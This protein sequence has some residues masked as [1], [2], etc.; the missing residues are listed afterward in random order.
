MKF[1]TEYDLR[2]QFNE[3]PFTDYKMEEN[4]RLTPGARQFLSD[5]RI[6]LFESGTKTPFGASG[7]TLK[8]QGTAGN[9]K[10]D[11]GRLRETVKAEENS[12]AIAKL[13]SDMEILEAEF[14]VI[15]SQIIGEDIE[16][17]GQISGMGHELGRLKSI[18]TGESAE[19]DICF[20][21][22][23]GMNGENC[24]QD[25]GNCFEISDFYIQ[26]ANGKILVQLNALRAKVRSVR[27]HVVEVLSGSEDGTRL[28]VVT[29][30]MNQ[31]VN[32]LSQMICKAAGVKECRRIQ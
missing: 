3:Q 8:T 26:S 28:T 15:T 18:L 32:K 22:C 2:A 25:L 21:E 4:T 5:R 29:G 16:S 14:F 1:I 6:N 23:T 9:L 27:I 19:P 31:I 17:A 30:V 24:C 7:G 20:D 12:L 13:V 11:A 10:P